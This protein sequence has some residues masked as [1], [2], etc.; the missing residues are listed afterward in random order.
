MSYTTEETIYWE[1]H[2]GHGPGIYLV[3]FESGMS[4]LEAT[5]GNI[6]RRISQYAEL[7]DLHEDPVTGYRAIEC[8][9]PF[10]VVNVVREALVERG[11]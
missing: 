2:R 5:R 1:W 9:H 8:D 4:R 7:G 11:Y 3:S 6:N 10:K